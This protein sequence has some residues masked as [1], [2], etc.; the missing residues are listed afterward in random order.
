MQKKEMIDDDERRVECNISQLIV[1]HDIDIINLAKAAVGPLSGLIAELSRYKE[2]KIP[3]SI[4]G[5]ACY[6]ER[7]G[8]VRVLL[9]RGTY[10]DGKGYNKFESPLASACHATMSRWPESPLSNGRVMKIIDLLISSGID[11][12]VEFKATK[13]T[14]WNGMSL[15]GVPMTALGSCAMFGRIELCEFLLNRGANIHHPRLMDDACC[16][17]ILDTSLPYMQVVKMLISKGAILNSQLWTS[18]VAAIY[19]EMLDILAEAK[20]P[21]P[22]DWT[23][24]RACREGNIDVIRASMRYGAKEDEEYGARSFWY[25]RDTCGRQLWKESISTLCS[26]QHPAVGANSPVNCL[27]SEMLHLISEYLRDDLFLPTPFL[28]AYTSPY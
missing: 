24:G 28:D 18:A 11:V 10:Y 23:L 19:P 5:L 26:A 16:D 22:P 4:L 13:S 6:Y 15:D 20:V 7:V 12:N 8:N 21:I 14:G 9:E 2:D 17:C 27:P 3:L 25:C 1:K